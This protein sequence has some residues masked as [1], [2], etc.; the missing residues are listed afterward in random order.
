MDSLKMSGPTCGL[1]TDADTPLGVCPQMSAPQA[2]PEGGR[3]RTLCGH[4]HCVR[5]VHHVRPTSG[6]GSRLLLAGSRPGRPARSRDARIGQIRCTFPT[7]R[8][9]SGDGAELFDSV[10]LSVQTDLPCRRRAPTPWLSTR[11][12]TIRG[13]NPATIQGGYRETY[14]RTGRSPTWVSPKDFFL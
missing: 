6:A 13:F 7:L 8:L 2:P 5:N 12:P 14:R 9:P 1:R 4:V 10:S 3:E 11:P